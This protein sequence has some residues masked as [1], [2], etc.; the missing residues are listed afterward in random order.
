MQFH[1]VPYN[2]LLQNRT[3]VYYKMRQV[4]YYKIWQFYYKLRRFYYKMQ[5]LFQ[6]VTVHRLLT[7]IVT[8]TRHDHVHFPELFKIDFFQNGCCSKSSRSQMFFRK[9][10]KGILTIFTGKYLCWSLIL[11]SLQ[12]FRPTTLLKR[13]YSTGVF[14]L[15]LQTF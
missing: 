14:L 2:N 8:V 9:I 1:L 4:F 12:V 15:K 5:R 3:I 7:F 6:I 11:I 13:D 10:L